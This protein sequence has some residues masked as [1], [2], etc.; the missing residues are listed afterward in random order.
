MKKKTDQPAYAVLLIRNKLLSPRATSADAFSLWCR[1]CEDPEVVKRSQKMAAAKRP[2]Y[3]A[4][5]ASGYKYAEFVL[6]QMDAKSLQALRGRLG[7]RPVKE[8]AVL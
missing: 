8:F 1:L 2:A 7:I 5:F 3:L 6:K 4:S